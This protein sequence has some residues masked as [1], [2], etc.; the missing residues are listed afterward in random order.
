V[1]HGKIAPRA[2]FNA[3]VPE[4]NGR[5][6]IKIQHNPR[7][8]R[9]KGVAGQTDHFQLNPSGLSSW[10]EFPRRLLD[11]YCSGYE[12]FA[13]SSKFAPM[14]AGDGQTISVTQH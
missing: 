2:S 12:R 8:C 13:R 11:W 4:A 1:V 7:H 6:P 3:L 5:V 14:P 10:G 9:V